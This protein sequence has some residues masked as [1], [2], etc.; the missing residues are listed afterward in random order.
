MCKKILCDDKNLTRM[1]DLKTNVLNALLLIIVF[2]GKRSYIQIHSQMCELNHTTIPV[3]SIW[4]GKKDDKIRTKKEHFEAGMC[5]KNKNI[6][7]Q[8]KFPGSYNKKGV[9]L[10]GNNQRI[11][12]KI[13]VYSFISNK[14]VTF[15]VACNIYDFLELILRKFM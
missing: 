11:C 6:E 8:A 4:E 10:T 15:V 13:H 14:D 12:N 7:A 1:I 2:L 5:M 9:Y 3:R